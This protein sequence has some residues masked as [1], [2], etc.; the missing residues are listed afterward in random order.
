MS[1]GLRIFKNTTYLTLGDKIGYLIQFLFFLYFARKFG[2]VPTG[3]YSFAFTFTFA[4]AVFA[5]F[6][7]AIYLVREV[8]R[9]YSSGRKLFFDCLVLRIICLSVIF[10]LASIILAVSFR[11]I[12]PAKLRVIICWGI[13][14]V[15]YSL[16]D[17]FLAEL[18]GH[19]KM[20][21]VALLG[22][23]LRLTATLAGVTLI[24]LGFPYHVVLTVLPLSSSLYLCASVLV[25][26]YYLGKPKIEFRSFKHYR[27]LIRELLPFFFSV[28]LVELLWC[29]D[30]LILGFIRDDQAVGIYSSALKIVAFILGMSPFF[31]TAILPVLSRLFIESE[32]QLI[33]LSNRILRYLIL[34]SLPMS[35]GLTMI[36]DK[37]IR[38]L[39]SDIFYESTIVLQ[40]TSWTITV[41]FIQAIYS[42][43]LTAIDRQK[44]KVIFI[45]MNFLISTLL[46]IILIYYFSY[47]GAA[48]VKLATTI[49]GLGFF[50]ILVSR[51]LKYLPLFTSI[52]KP[53]FACLVMSIFIYYF[54][55][56]NLIIL[57]PTAAFIYL[58]SLFILGVFTEQEIGFVKS[59]FP[60]TLYSR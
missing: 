43:I 21:Q 7:I 23:C 55:S 32:S 4:F 16:A 60:R 10:V 22:L 8:A 57:I 25:S 24:Y 26:I 42:V 37:I 17:V 54:A 40:I 45:G 12:S 41:G 48:V 59:C 31:H 27:N 56:W 6:G 35:I 14:W 34:G 33:D 1:L 20:G 13:Y 18:N 29:Q 11:D 49:I 36:S 19:E 44:E 28:I 50:I 5:D 30:I 38:I 51:Y 39:Y 53:G 46:N 47:L 58:L 3:E 52:I 15:F 9:D 2:V